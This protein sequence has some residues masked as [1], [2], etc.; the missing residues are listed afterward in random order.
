MVD[1]AN[2]RGLKDGVS[3]VVEDAVGVVHAVVDRSDRDS[4]GFCGA[5]GG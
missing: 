3:V 5:R 1:I 4:M 2:A